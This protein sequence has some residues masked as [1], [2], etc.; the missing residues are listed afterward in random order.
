MTINLPVF[1]DRVFKEINSLHSTVFNIKSEFSETL[2]KMQ[3]QIDS[4]EQQLNKKNSEVIDLN[5]ENN[6]L[7]KKILFI[8]NLVNCIIDKVNNLML[9][10]NHLQS[11]INIGS[12]YI[13]KVDFL[14]ETNNIYK[15]ISTITQSKSMNIPS[16]SNQSANITSNSISSNTMASNTM[17]SNSPQIDINI[18]KIKSEI[19]N[20]IIKSISD[21]KTI[22]N[23]LSVSKPISLNSQNLEE[24][25]NVLENQRNSNAGWTVVKN[26]KKT[27]NNYK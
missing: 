6:N 24:S 7:N 14:K 18:D 19:Y 8:E 16:L 23:E 13:N 3:Y 27:K 2:S 10:Q 11:Q 26:K 20:D 21:E 15:L 17:A 12:D 5:N 4:L 1:D 22:L 9:Y 25:L